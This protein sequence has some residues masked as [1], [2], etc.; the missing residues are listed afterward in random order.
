MADESLDRLVESLSQ[1]N[2]H[3][4]GLRVTMG[5]LTEIKLDHEQRLRA[6]ER[7]QQNLTPFLAM[8]TFILGGVVSAALDKYL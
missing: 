6:V 3:L 7:W 2:A 8:M 4:E 5:A 1:V